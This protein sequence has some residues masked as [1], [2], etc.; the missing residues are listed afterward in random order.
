MGESDTLTDP[1]SPAV[2]V[3][4]VENHRRFL[5]FVQKRVGNAEEILQDA[6]AKGVARAGEIRDEERAVAWF[7]RLLRNA[8]IDHW[9]ARDVEARGAEAFALNPGKA[10]GRAEHKGKTYFFCSVSGKS[11]FEANP[12][13]YA[14]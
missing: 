6:L 11:K 4:L 1:P 12:G 7:Y 14:K 13:Q 9:R 8:V 2:V 10:A 5:S 3:R